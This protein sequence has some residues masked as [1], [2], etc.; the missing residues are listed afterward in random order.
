[1]M[2]GTSDIRYASASAG[3]TELMYLSHREAEESANTINAG[4]PKAWPSWATDVKRCGLYV[5]KLAV[6]L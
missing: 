1:M 6:F 5:N 3:T 4:M 2:A